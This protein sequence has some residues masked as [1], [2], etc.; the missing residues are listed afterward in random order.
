[1]KFT[2][3]KYLMAEIHPQHNEKVAKWKMKMSEN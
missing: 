2:A 3:I 1:M